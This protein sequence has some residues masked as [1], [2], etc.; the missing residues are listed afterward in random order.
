MVAVSGNGSAQVYLR[1]GVIR[2]ERYDISA[3]ESGSVPQIPAD[4]VDFLLSVDGVALVAGMERGEVVVRSRAGQA[5]L[6][7]IDDR[8]IRYSPDTADVLDL[9]P[10]A[11]T[12]TERQWLEQSL[13]RAYPDAPAQLTQLFRSPRTGELAVV[14][15]PGVDLRLEWEIP[16]HKSGHG[17]LTYDH[18]RCL[19]AADRPLLGPVR[20]VDIF[21]LVLQHLGYEIP[22]GIDGVTPRI[23]SEK[24]EVA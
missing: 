11:Q 23:E 8:H 3:I 20:T 19:V 2:G 17:S 7:E 14:A 21:P 1:P 24:R 15:E 22:A 16:E 9:A 5:R 4:L 18:M 12:L 13:D 6:A 10:R